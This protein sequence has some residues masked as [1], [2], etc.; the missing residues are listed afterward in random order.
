VDEAIEDLIKPKA[1]FAL[2][3]FIEVANLTSVQDFALSA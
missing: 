1:V 2:S 3:V